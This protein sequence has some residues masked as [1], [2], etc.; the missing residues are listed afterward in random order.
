MFFPDRE[1]FRKKAAQGNLIPVYKEILADLETPVSAFRKIGRGNYAFLLES[2]EA[3]EK[4]ARQTFLGGEPFAI[5]ESRGR[6]VTIRRD[7]EAETRELGPEEDPLTALK[8]LL[9]EYRFVPVAGLPRFCG[10]AVGYIGYDCVRFFERLPELAK[11]DLDLP[12]ALLVL[13]DTC[14][15]F[16]H[17]RHR[18]KILSNALVRGSADDAYNAAVAKIEEI[19]ERL[20]Q[21]PA[22]TPAPKKAAAAPST[23]FN[24]SREAYEAAVRRAKQYI[25]AGDCIQ[26]VLSQR[27]SRP[28]VADPFD[29]YRALRSINPSPYMYYLTYGDLKIIGSSPERLVSEEDGVVVTRPIAGSRPRGADAAEDERLRADLL[30]DEKERAEH[31]MLV[32]LGR[33]DIGRV[34]RAGSVAVDELMGIEKYSHV[35]HIVSNVR[36]QLSPGRDQFDVLRAC[37]PA[38]TLS[39]APKIRAMEIIEELEPTRRGPYGGAIGYFSFSGN[40]DT[41]IT[42]RTIVVKE[43]MAHLQVGAGIVADSQPEREYDECVKMKAGALLRAIELAEDGLR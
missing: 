23:I 39:G 27:L 35:M 38:G 8:S 16:D 7:G 40:M 24:M 18:V 41:A 21:P 20:A 5:F 15:M 36:G 10:G 2:V 17:A 31:I 30:A 19:E 1:E 37:F 33:N 34:C 29:I 43:G 22:A 4:I 13:T 42:I 11:D 32:D 25:A 3:G 14:L 28:V 26:V 9:G 6:R 12:D